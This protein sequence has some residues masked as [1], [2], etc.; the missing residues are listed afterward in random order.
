MTMDI[1]KGSFT[2][3]NSSQVEEVDL[4]EYYL[5][6]T[7]CQDCN[8]ASVSQTYINNQTNRQRRVCKQCFLIAYRNNTVLK[9]VSVEDQILLS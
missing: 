6:L 8:H 4:V 9:E 7:P 3:L 1:D 2:K 5:G